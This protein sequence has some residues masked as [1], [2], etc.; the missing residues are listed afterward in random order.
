M[1]FVY[2]M[3]DGNHEVKVQAGRRRQ[4]RL[5]IVDDRRRLFRHR[6]GI[7]LFLINA[8]LIINTILLCIQV[9]TDHF[10]HE[11][12]TVTLVILHHHIGITWDVVHLTISGIPFRTPTT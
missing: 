4:Q 12:I 6:M 9:R 8:T 3:N 11:E 1:L 10:H 7:Y 5:V 2:L